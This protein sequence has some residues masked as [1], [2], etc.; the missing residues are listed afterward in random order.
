MC[1]L[2][3]FT[4]LQ[5]KP[6]EE[7]NLNSWLHQFLSWDTTYFEDEVWRGP[8]AYLDSSVNGMS[9]LTDKDQRDASKFIRLLDSLVNAETTYTL[10]EVED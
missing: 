4:N 7:H 5:N 10:K 8:L 3:Q 1:L 9:L 6:G 2:K